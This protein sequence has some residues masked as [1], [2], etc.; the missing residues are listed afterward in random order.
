[1]SEVKLNI[2]D[3][4]RAICGTCHGSEA[5]A[6]VAALSAE[7]ETIE[8]LQA[9][10]G[11][12]MKPGGDCRPLELFSAG[13]D[14]EPWDAGIVFID[15]AA[16]IVA[17]DSSCC[18]PAAEG[19]IAF[20]D[21]ARATNVRLPYYLPD[22][23]LFLDCID[24]YEAVRDRRCAERGKVATLDARPVLYGTVLEFI[25]RK[26][27]AA[28]DA[29][30]VDPIAEIHA[31]WLMTP[32]ADLHGQSPREV[33]LAKREF[34]DMDLQS[35]E[36]QWSFLGEAAPC[37]APDS[38][39]YRYA[40]VGTHEAVVYYELLR[41]LLTECWQH[42]SKKREVSIAGEVAR[43][44]R[45]K[46]DWLETPQP[47]YEDKSPAWVLECERKRLPLV[48]SPESIMDD[49]CPLCR[50]MAE[51]STPTF[52][53][54]DGC[55][56]DPDVPFSFFQTRD[57]W[58]ENERSFWEI[59]GEASRKLEQQRGTVLDEGKTTHHVN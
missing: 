39:A 26:C 30:A 28:R 34:I 36:Q 25:V 2:L 17:A 32:R 48:A 52:W 24:E 40:G 41:Y 10:M 50:M 53:H 9:A 23:W 35:R 21:G 49:D 55:N 58:E 43:L 46:A 7:P 8:E 20:H 14:R 18:M 47:D 56:M 51:S 11:R 4:E 16:R 12:F 54:L 59:T 38:A 45:I 19:H 5:D 57:E 31:G 22:D 29:N 13:T 6:A 27:L 1:M 37:L 15:L 33:L 42:V 44:E 3:S